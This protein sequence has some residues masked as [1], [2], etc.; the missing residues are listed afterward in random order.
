V[1]VTFA[2]PLACGWSV[3]LLLRGRDACSPRLRTE[4]FAGALSLALMATAA[5]LM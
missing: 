3:L 2:V 5:V 1:L 4:R